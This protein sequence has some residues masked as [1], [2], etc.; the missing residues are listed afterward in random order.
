[1]FIDA[2]FASIATTLLVAL[3]AFQF[4]LVLGA[5]WGRFAWGGQH[6]I[7]PMKLRVGSA[8][9]IILYMFFALIILGMSGLVGIINDMA[10]LFL[11]TYILA[12][13]F[14]L[15]IFMN[16]I[17]RSKSERLVMTPVSALLALSYIV[18]AA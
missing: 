9:S 16:A 2:L 11:G 3:S 17:S 15:G 13:Y 18:V 14:V 4:A 7:L 12:G 10:V 5:P 8:L 6:D 1:M